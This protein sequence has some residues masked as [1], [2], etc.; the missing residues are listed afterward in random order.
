[1]KRRFFDAVRCLTCAACALFLVPVLFL[2]CDD[3]MKSSLERDFMSEYV[4]FAASPEESLGSESVTLSYPIGTELSR[5]DLPTVADARFAALKPGYTVDGW[6]YYKNPLTDS[7]DVPSTVTL[8]DADGTISRIIV[9]SYPAWLY[10]SGWSAVNYTLVLD[11]NGGSYT[12]TDGI[13]KTQVTQ[14][15]VYD[16]SQ[17]LPKNIFSRKGYTFNGWNVAAHRN[18]TTPD[19]SD[20][21]EVT[22]LATTEGATVTF[23]ACWVK[24]SITISFDANGGTGS[25]ENIQA[26]ID[27]TLPENQFTRTGWSFAGWSTSAD[28]SGT[29]F[30]DKAVLLESNYPNEN[31]TLYAQWQRNTYLVTYNANNGRITPYTESY[32]YG[33]SVTIAD[34]TSISEFETFGY[35][36]VDWNTAADGSGATFKSGDTFVIDENGLTLYAQWRAQTVTITFDANGGT[37]AMSALT[38]S[39]DELPVTLPENAFTRVGYSFANWDSSVGTSYDDQARISKA[40]WVSGTLTLTAQWSANPFTVT[41]LSNNGTS[42][43]TTQTFYYDVAQNLYG[44]VFSRTGY[45]FIG[46]NTSADGSGTSYAASETIVITKEDLTLYAQWSVQTL[47][48][49]F[50]ANGGTGTMAAQTM[51]YED[52][53]VTLSKNAFSY[54]GYYFI[55]WAL[56]SSGSGSKYGDGTAI[57]ATNWVTGTMMLYAV[58]SRRASVV[59]TMS[60]GLSVVY[61]EDD[62][63]FSVSDMYSSYKWLVDGE[64]VTNNTSYSITLNYDDYDE[65]ATKTHSIILIA[66]E[67]DA[68]LLTDVPVV[69][70]ASFRVHEE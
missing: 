33:S 14:S 40:N 67:Y 68:D 17:T 65:D 60:T 9:T 7:Y 32:E 16:E 59:G 20:G 38:L 36:F 48:I 26:Q 47:T 27:D 28:G 61:G 3:D 39:Y 56:S 53:P 55:N 46:W 4:Y 18:Q 63:T 51:T 52:L 70:N 58:W 21:E 49:V 62:F 69:F 54:P 22:N 10:A 43:Q 1:M 50:D 24:D 35:D 19:Y 45:D 31:C 44:E 41:Y 6:L 2:S 11:A 34:G 29:Y 13:T 25:M 30:A 12:N 37:G 66:Y 15:F 8:S 5:I 42:V 57:T 64:E 23:Y